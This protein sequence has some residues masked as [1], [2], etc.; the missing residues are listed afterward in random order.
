MHDN[1]FTIVVPTCNRAAL[2]PRALDS[3]L[4]QTLP[5]F[6]VVVVDDG[7]TDETPAVVQRY[8]H[9][10]RFVYRRLPTWSGETIARNAAYDLARGKLIT[11][12]DDDDWLAPDALETAYR[13]HIDLG[14]QDPHWLLFD[15]ASM[16]GGKIDNVTERVEG[17]LRYQ[18]ILCGRVSGNF[19][20]VYSRDLI[21]RP[22]VRHDERLFGNVGQMYLQVWRRCPPYYVP[23]ALYFANKQG[24]ARLSTVASTPVSRARDI[25]NN[26]IYLSVF[27]EDLRRYC[28]R[29]IGGVLS[30]TG[31]L[32]ASN[33]R[34]VRSLR[35]HVR[36]LR[37]GITRDTARYAALSLVAW[38]GSVFTRLHRGHAEAG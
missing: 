4:A 36:A 20:Q 31:Y 12:L 23:R 11:Y 13:Y 29:A 33:G 10:P 15:C 9:D 14:S 1:T 19:W 24:H 17:Y 5:H 28:P 22:R 6:T 8:L 3:I 27:A 16:P 37:Y 21:E 2:L 35:C 26:E 34:P 30:R 18:D 32:Q 38:G 25:T 7:S